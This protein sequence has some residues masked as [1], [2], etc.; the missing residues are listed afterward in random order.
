M[1]R[2]RGW[3]DLTFDGEDLFVDHRGNL[4]RTVEET[5]RPAM[6]GL[7]LDS[8]FLGVVGMARDGRTW[9]GVVDAEAAAD[10]REE[11]VEEG[12]DLVIPDFLA[13]EHATAGAVD[14]AAEAGLKPDPAAVRR[15][16]EPGPWAQPADQYWPDLLAALG[17]SAAPGQADRSPA[18]PSSTDVPHP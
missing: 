4:A 16:F 12:Y 13:P 1:D 10:Y 17:I 14:W 3:V 8:D 6:I 7:T 2:A 15:I 11:G 18:E 5:G 9:S